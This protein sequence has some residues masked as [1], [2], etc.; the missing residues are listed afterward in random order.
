MCSTE[1]TDQQS[2]ADR[3]NSVHDDTWS[4]S[5]AISNGQSFLDGRVR[6][7]GVRTLNYYA[8]GILDASIGFAPFPG[9][10]HYTENRSRPRITKAYL[11]HIALVGEPA[12]DT[13]NVC[14]SDTRCGCSTWSPYESPMIGGLAPG[15]P[16][17][18]RRCGWARFD[19]IIRWAERTQMLS[20]GAGRGRPARVGSMTAPTPNLVHLRW[21][22]PPRWRHRVASG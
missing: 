22:V 8:D 6:D 5:P 7:P 3:R 20:A 17:R 2:S 19:G 16:K 18:I 10:E 12:Y 21:S 4:L 15:T 11:G 14:R 13:A 1:L 9:G